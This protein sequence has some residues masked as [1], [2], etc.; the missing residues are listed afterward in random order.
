MARGN[1]NIKSAGCSCFVGIAKN[2]PPMRGSNSN[3]T[4]DFLLYGFSQYPKGYRKNSRCRS[5]ETEHPKRYQI[6]FYNP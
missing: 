1:C 3:T 2:L 6:C 5:F 4:Q